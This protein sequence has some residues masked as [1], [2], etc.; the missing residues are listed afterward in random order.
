MFLGISIAQR[1]TA[2]T[3]RSCRPLRIRPT[4]AAAAATA[5]SVWH[6]GYLDQHQADDLAQAI[7]TTKNELEA[8]KNQAHAKQ[9]ELDNLNKDYENLTGE[10]YE[11]T[12]NDIEGSSPNS[13][14]N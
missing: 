5:R 2:A 12:R 10:S 1:S 13:K 4:A 9:E 6:T 8:L 7:E 11:S 3:R 14:S